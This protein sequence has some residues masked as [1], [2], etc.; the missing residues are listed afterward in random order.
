MSD[1][2]RDAP[3]GQI[4]RWTTN[5]RFLK[6]PEERADFQCPH[7]YA[8]PDSKEILPIDEQVPVIEPEGPAVEEEV[9][10]PSPET[11]LEK[12]VTENDTE[13]TAESGLDKIQTARTQHTARTQISRVGTKTALAKSISRADLEQQFSLATVERGPTRPIKPE[14]L[15]DGTIL[16]DWYTTDDPEN[17]QNWSFGK[18][19]VVLLQI[20]MYT[21]GV[22]MGSAIYSPSAEG[23]MERF[24]VSIG[25]ASLGL[26]M[27]VLAYGIGPVSVLSTDPPCDYC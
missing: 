5:K 13:S 10:Y 19:A 2:I 12:V 17:P 7:S 15:D 26:S 9:I 16:V 22:Y 23:V 1:L 25:S 24:G 18:K 8:H 21:M 11:V 27:Y 4:I 14:K 20:L 6:Y 3:I